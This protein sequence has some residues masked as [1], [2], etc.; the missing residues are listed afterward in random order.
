MSPSESDDDEAAEAT[1]DKATIKLLTWAVSL[2]LSIVLG[3]TGWG[4]LQ[5]FDQS[6]KAVDLVEKEQ[7]ARIAAVAAE[8]KARADGLAAEQQA[9]L[10]LERRE[11]DLRAEQQI[12]NAT[13]AESLRAV[14]HDLDSVSNGHAAHVDKDG[15]ASMEAQVQALR[16]DITEI[17][18]R[19]DG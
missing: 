16:Q 6:A 17:R 9:R 3:M 19:L 12:I 5:A 2:L 13:L 14:R 11:Q 1:V 7:A 8:S 18:A 4:A 10:A 15:H